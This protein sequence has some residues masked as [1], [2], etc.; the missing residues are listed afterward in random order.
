[1]EDLS[2]FEKNQFNPIKVSTSSLLGNLDTADA[3]ASA[4]TEGKI[5]EEY[6]NGKMYYVIPFEFKMTFAPTFQVGDK[7]YG[8]KDLGFLFYT[9]LSFP[10]WLKSSGQDVPAAGEFYE[11]LIIDGP[12]AQKLF[13]ETPRLQKQEKL[14]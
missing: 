2:I 3:L 12:Q 9:F 8:M 14:L 4:V 7:T 13:L 6:K 11:S 10:D 1:M 5:R